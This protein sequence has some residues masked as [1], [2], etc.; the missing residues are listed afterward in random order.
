[1]IIW[2]SISHYSL[3]RVTDPIIAVAAE[4]SM[5]EAITKLFSGPNHI[6]LAPPSLSKILICSNA[7]TD[8]KIS[9]SGQCGWYLGIKS[10]DTATVQ[11][12]RV[13]PESHLEHSSLTVEDSFYFTCLSGIQILGIPSPLLTI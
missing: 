6:C 4:L 9:F 7:G 10:R 2:E 5:A 1:M 13:P 11:G 3:F 12:G 8:P